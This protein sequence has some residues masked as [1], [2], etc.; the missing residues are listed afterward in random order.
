MNDEKNCKE[1]PEGHMCQK[2]CK[3]IIADVPMKLHSEIKEMSARRGTTIRNY[4]L[5]AIISRLIT[6]TKNQ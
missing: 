1:L 6:D 4:I 5:Q 2:C 3:R